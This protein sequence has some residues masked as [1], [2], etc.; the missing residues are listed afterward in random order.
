MQNISS[1]DVPFWVKK[2]KLS[3][4]LINKKTIE[5]PKEY[6]IVNLTIQNDDEYITVLKAMEYWDID[7][8]PFRVYEYAK[9]YFNG[10]LE[11]VFATDDFKNFKFKDELIL[12]NKHGMDYDGQISTYAKDDCDG[13]D[14]NKYTINFKKS[15]VNG[16]FLN[17]SKFI[18]T[19]DNMKYYGIC[20]D[21]IRAKNDSMFKY[22]FGQ[23]IQI[24]ANAY[25]IIAE[26]G[27]LDMLKLLYN[28]QKQFHYVTWDYY[29]VDA[30]IIGGH[31]NCLKFL[32]ENKCVYSS[33]SNSHAAKHG[34]F[35]C[36]KYLHEKKIGN[37]YDKGLI[38][39]AAIGGCMKCLQFLHKNN[40]EGKTF[41]YTYLDPRQSHYATD[42]AASKG[43]LECLKFLKNN[44]YLL[45]N[46]ACTK[47]A[48]HGHLEVLKY[49]LD[50]GC[51][52]NINIKSN[53]HD[54]LIELLQTKSDKI[55]N[56][57]LA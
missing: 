53:V 40:V 45:N 55:L 25:K 2:S 22:L 7:D 48:Q 21:A 30:A 29:A 18:G 31:L 24:D 51:K 43:H 6:A 52:W 10:D 26:N 27:N 44:G 50:I 14:C 38:T 46:T 37:Y 19:T 47:A 57:A 20:G 54:Y 16:G 4:S 34:Q 49:L 8:V 36:L 33:Y 5:V 56:I 1:K 41:K 17:L 32:I 23:G 42:H 15:V 3:R 9:Y 13:G 35:E 39:N 28:K 11:K 12:I